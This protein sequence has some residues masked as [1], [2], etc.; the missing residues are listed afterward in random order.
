MSSPE[1]LVRADRIEL[2]G[3]AGLVKLLA[4]FTYKP[5]WRFELVPGDYSLWSTLVIHTWVQD[6]YPPHNW[7]GGVFQVPVPPRD[8]MSEDDWMRWLRHQITAAEDHET[9]EWFLVA[10]KRPFDPH[11]AR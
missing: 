8:E 2:L 5:R 9:C 7:G 3:P 4:E 11:A 10:G 1:P 6:A